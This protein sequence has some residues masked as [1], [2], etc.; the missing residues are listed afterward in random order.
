MTL[1]EHDLLQQIMNMKD[2]LYIHIFIITI[3]F[4]IITGNLRGLILRNSSGLNSSIGFKG[5]LKHMIVILIVLTIFPYLTLLN[6]NS[7]AITIVCF[8]ILNYSISI[9]ENLS[10]MGIKLPPFIATRLSKLTNKK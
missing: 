1:N 5:L 8:Y 4:D 2:N 3:L 7:Y 10:Q 6:F 9:L